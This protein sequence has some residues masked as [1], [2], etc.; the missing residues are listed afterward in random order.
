MRGMGKSVVP[1]I[2]AQFGALSRIP[3]AYFLGVKPNNQNGMFLALA[4]AS[5]MRSLAIAIYYFCGGWNQAKASY[6]KKHPLPERETI[7]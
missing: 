2:T 6:L 4:L 3:F 1:M 5:L 7:K